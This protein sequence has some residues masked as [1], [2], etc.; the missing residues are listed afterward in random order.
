MIVYA[1]MNS[2]LVATKL[3]WADYEYELI[4]ILLSS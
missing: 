1:A 2:L 4:Y 3:F